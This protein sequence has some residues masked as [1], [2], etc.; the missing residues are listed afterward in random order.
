[1]KRKPLTQTDCPI[2]RSLERVGDWWSILILR[3]ALH[4]FT[5]FDQFQ[6]SLSIAPNILTARLAKFVEDGLMTRQRYSER[7]PRDAYLLT[8]AG[9]DFE[10]VLVALLAWGNTHFAPEGESVVVLDTATGQV[11]D[12][13]LVDRISGRALSSPDFSFGAGPTANE[14][15]RQRFENRPERQS[16]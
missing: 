10:P 8:D 1:M 2:A 4:G 7:P 5:R 15:V 3:D 6:K 13:I 14:W 11:A 12:P 9:R 16:R